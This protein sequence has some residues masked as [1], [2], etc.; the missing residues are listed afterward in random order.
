MVHF[1][2]LARTAREGQRGEKRPFGFAIKDIL[3]PC[4]SV[5]SIDV[6]IMWQYFIVKNHIGE[7]CFCYCEYAR[8]RRVNK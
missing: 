8:S 6:I 3:T 5:F 1:P 2:E 7:P 4:I